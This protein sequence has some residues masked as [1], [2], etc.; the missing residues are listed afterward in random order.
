MAEEDLGQSKTEAPTPRRR[1]EAREQGQVASSTDLGGAVLLLVG[2]ISLWIGGEKLAAQLSGLL[3]FSWSNL[4]VDDF[5]PLKAHALLTGHFSQA[6]EILGMLLGLLAV[7]GLIT[8]VAQVGF[9]ITPSQL[10]PKWEKLNPATGWQ[11]LFSKQAVMRGLGAI[12]K[13]VLVVVLSWVVLRG[14][15]ASLA[16]LGEGSLPAAATLA[17]G[18]VMRLAL[19]IALALV[20]L[21]VS[22]Y[23]F[24]WWRLEQ[25]LKMTRQELKEEI[26]REEGDPH[27]KARIRRLQREMAQRRM[28]AQVPRSTVVVTNPTRLAVAIRYVRGS[29]G[30]PQVVAKGRGFIARRIVSLARRHGVPILERRPLTQAL[31]RKVAV[32]GEVPPVH[33]DALAEVLVLVFRMR[34]PT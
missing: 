17:W 25:A 32:E 34:M 10:G 20:L 12:L 9:H 19:A 18:L 23:L 5:G 31:F 1:Q 27:I 28:M 11:R 7:A 14:R 29:R 15:V 33:F 30:A 26:K 13:I 22:D 24:Q 16:T 6:L 2:V 21:G 4:S 8:A 3:R